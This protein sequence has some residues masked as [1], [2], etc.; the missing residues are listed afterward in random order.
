MNLVT[1][2]WKKVR[3]N[4]AVM[5]DDAVQHALGM[6]TA[7][8]GH[9]APHG[10]TAKPKACS[11]QGQGNLNGQAAKAKVAPYRLAVTKAKAAP[12]GHAAAKA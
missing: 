2:K 10:H 6:P 4:F 11:N 1:Q 9:A 5:Q 7:C 12:H 3:A 8:L